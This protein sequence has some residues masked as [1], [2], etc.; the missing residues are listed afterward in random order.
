MTT[1]HHPITRLSTLLPCFRKIVKDF[2]DNG[3]YW[4]ML[5]FYQGGLRAPRIVDT[6]DKLKAKK[7]LA[8]FLKAWGKPQFTGQVS[9]YLKHA[10]FTDHFNVYPGAGSYDEYL[11]EGIQFKVKTYYDQDEGMDVYRIEEKGII[12]KKDYSDEIPF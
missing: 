2:R 6:G 9:F 12:K 1:E 10:E 4:L 5:H 7:E 11:K 3:D 8:D